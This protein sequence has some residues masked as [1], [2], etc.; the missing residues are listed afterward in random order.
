MHR[1]APYVA[2]ASPKGA[3]PEQSILL[4]S[5]GHPLIALFSRGTWRNW[6]TGVVTLMAF[7][8]ETLVI[9]LTAVPF[10]TATAYEAHQVSV[11]IS[12]TILGVMILTVPAVL[13]WQTRTKTREI[14]KMPECIAD[15]LALIAGEQHWTVL[16][17]LS[18][19]ERRQVVKGWGTK[20]GIRRAHGR[21]QI[22]SMP[23]HPSDGGI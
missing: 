13:F 16:G 1:T 17:M 5:H 6:L 12:I 15:V 3:T 11:Y 8:S 9:M 18:D 21:L 10:T 7:L 2:L 20:F 14:P 22:V 19:E 23:V 4:Q